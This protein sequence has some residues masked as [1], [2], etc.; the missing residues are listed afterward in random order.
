MFASPLHR[1]DGRLLAPAL[2][3]TCLVPRLCGAAGNGGISADEAERRRQKIEQLSKIDRD[4]LLHR[5]REFLALSEP[6]KNKFRELHRG[7]EADTRSGG[8]L[9]GV[10]AAYREWLTTLS[11]WQQRELRKETDPA[12]KL[13]LVWTFKEEQQREEAERRRVY[14][15]T[16]GP[17]L[18]RIPGYWRRLSPEE[19][20]A[21]LRVV[22]MESRPTFTKTRQQELDALAGLNR[23]LLLLE[24]VLRPDPQL[25]GRADGPWP[26]DRLLEQMIAALEEENVRSRFAQEPNTDA[27]RQLL[28]RMLIGGLFFELQQEAE[29][30]LAED[31]T[32]PE[33]SQQL[34]ADLDDRLR[35]EIMKLPV[36]EM[37]RRLSLM[38]LTRH[39]ELSAVDMQRL[40]GVLGEL[41]R[42]AGFRPLPGP[43]VRRPFG[44]G[45][46]LPRPDGRPLRD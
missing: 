40:R 4:R 45:G 31:A 7:L 29:R 34:F 9:R 15:G 44:G 28:V 21:V 11:P 30:R 14:P 23:H 12:K 8:Q 13:R 33:K 17:L 1:N 39:P 38:Y 24:S 42:R 3:L 16:L 20:D 46:V 10:L 43:G 2:L 22:E 6:E 5:Y 19:L 37:Q 26:S 35:D 32:W 18:G 41:S 36:P 27:R 25:G